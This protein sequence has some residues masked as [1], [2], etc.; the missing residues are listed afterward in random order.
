MINSSKKYYK[1][2]AFFFK[3][4][5]EMKSIFY[6]D[7]EKALL[8]RYFKYLREIK[9]I[10]ISD[11]VNK[12]ICDYK[13]Y[14]GIEEGIP[15]SN[16]EFY[17]QFI[18]FYQIDVQGIKEYQ[19]MIPFFKQLM[20]LCE[21]YQE[22][23]IEKQINLFKEKHHNR[24]NLPILK[25]VNQTLHIIKSHYVDNINYYEE[26][27]YAFIPLIQLWKNELS[28]MLIEVC[29]QNNITNAL[30]MEIIEQLFPLL[31][32]KYFL[33]Y[34]WKARTLNIKGNFITSIELYRKC[35]K[36]SEN[37]KNRILRIMMDLFNVYRDIDQIKA[38]EY[39]EKIKNSLF[40]ESI[41]KKLHKSLC[42]N[43]AMFYYLKKDYQ[44][45]I[46]ISKT[47]LNYKKNM[48][49]ILLVCASKS[50]LH[51]ENE[52]NIEIDEQHA[53]A[54]YL[55]YYKLKFSKN[56]STE[57]EK[58]FIEKVIPRLMEEKNEYPYWDM[59]RFEMEE[60]VQR[61]RKY[62]NLQIFNNYFQKAMKNNA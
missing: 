32:D 15:K 6:S 55:N 21:D 17:D 35:L 57:L 4:D 33:D 39:A 1:F 38:L 58:Y 56:D 44:N 40:D 24:L 22:K 9:Q 2:A 52:L 7:E 29:E 26:D 49:I 41:P 43:L 23:E 51:I 28:S 60:L 20:N 53:L 34:Y 36:K 18:N 59:F 3:G 61:T 50:R 10:K 62:R 11:V 14:K 42:Y 8:G 27:I 54:V 48:K 19:Q 30:S 25:E 31:N 13:T 37:K 16:D 47:M 45:T 46:K 12:G 5:R